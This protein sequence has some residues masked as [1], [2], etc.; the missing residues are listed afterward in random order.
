MFC[1]FQNVALVNYIHSKLN[2]LSSSL[3][4]VIFFSNFMNL[5][6]MIVLLS[7]NATSCS[8]VTVVRKQRFFPCLMC[9]AAA[10]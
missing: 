5:S 8:V 4:V 1:H 3:L 9:A 7:A 2:V 10:A 6:G